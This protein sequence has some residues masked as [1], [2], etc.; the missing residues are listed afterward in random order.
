MI[1]FALVFVRVYSHDE[2]AEL[3]SGKMAWFLGLGLL[4]GAARRPAWRRGGIHPARALAQGVAPVARRLARAGHPL[5]VDD[6]V[7][8]APATWGGRARIAALKACAALS[9]C[10]RT[11]CGASCRSRRCIAP[12]TVA[13]ACPNSRPRTWTSA[14]SGR[15]PG[16]ARR[17]RRAV[18]RPRHVGRLWHQRAR[19]IDRVHVALA[20]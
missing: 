12:A 18:A 9:G 7:R 5:I 10:R 1:F 4:S 20:L 19:R 17:R 15:A 13:P 14:P 11:R 3:I 16:P 8:L 2:R 6:R